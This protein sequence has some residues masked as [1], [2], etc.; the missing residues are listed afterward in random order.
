[1]CPACK[2]LYVLYVVSFM[3]FM[4]RR[5]QRIV[6]RKGGMKCPLAGVNTE[7]CL[8]VKRY[9]WVVGF[10]KVRIKNVYHLT[11]SV[12]FESWELSS[13]TL[14]TTNELCWKT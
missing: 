11:V 10:S 9:V 3:T 6:G 12:F 8:E 14:W 1:M 7:N 2:I 13:V 4:K 5:A